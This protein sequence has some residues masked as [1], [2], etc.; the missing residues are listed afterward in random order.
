MFIQIKT[1]FPVSKVNFFLNI[2]INNTIA[3]NFLS[4]IHEW[5]CLLLGSHLKEIIPNWEKAICTTLITSL[6]LK[7]KRDENT[8]IL[9]NTNKYLNTFYVPDTALSTGWEDQNTSSWC[10]TMMQWYLWII[11]GNT[12]RYYKVYKIVH[13]C[14]LYIYI[15][16]H[17]L[18]LPYKS[19]NLWIERT[20]IKYTKIL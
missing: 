3:Y 20:G 4:S 5:M 18:Q 2:A 12:Y 10:I 15:Y 1:C 17:K 19:K 6:F 7:E 13:V 16:T 14:I 11:R 9:T 8:E